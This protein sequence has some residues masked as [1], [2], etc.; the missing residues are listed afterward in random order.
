MNEIFRLAINLEKEAL[1]SYLR[2]GQQIKDLTGKDLFIRLAM[3]E[4]EHIEILERE[5]KYFEKEKGFEELEIPLTEIEKIVNHL[6]PSLP[7]EKK[8]SDLKELNILQIAL[9]LE[10]KSIDFY[11]NQEKLSKEDVSKK[12]WK[13]LKEIEESHYQLI[14][15]EID[16]LTKMGFWFDFREFSLEAEK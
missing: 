2:F 4:F 11:Q 6:K 7:K 16:Y 10:K 13:R 3:D 8:I 1:I 15:A 12:I 14:Q 5:L 9:S